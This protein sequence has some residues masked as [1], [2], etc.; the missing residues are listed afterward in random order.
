MLEVVTS[1]TPREKRFS[2]K[3]E[4]NIAS[5]MSDTKTVKMNSLFLLRG[6]LFIKQVH[7]P[8]FASTYTAP[9]VQTAD[10]LRFF[11]E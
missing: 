10:I 1:V 6:E 2:S 11:S 8:G 4:S 5:A 9:Q 7:Q 3:P